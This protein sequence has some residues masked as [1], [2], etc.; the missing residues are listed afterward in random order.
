M[1]RKKR[2]LKK[3]T[4]FGLLIFI[5]IFIILI[6]LFLN[7][8]KTDQY[9]LSKLGYNKTQIKSI[10]SL[11]EKDVETIK[12]VHYDKN[13]PAL[14]ETK[15]FKTDSFKEYYTYQKSHKTTSEE[16]I[17]IINNNLDKL[18]EYDERK[19]ATY[20]NFSKKANIKAHIAVELVNENIE[21]S[22]IILTLKKEKYYK[23]EHL[24][25]YLHYYKK[26]NQDATTIIRDVNANIDYE[27]YTNI[28]EADLTKKD[29]ILV[30]KYY[31]LSEDYVPENLVE[32]EDGYYATKVTSDAYLKMKQD[33]QK[34]GLSLAITSA[35][36]SYNTQDILYNRYTN[37]NGKTWADNYSA[38][39]GHSEHQ[40]GLA[41]DITSNS[42]NFDTFENTKEYQWLKNNSYKYGFIL[43]YQQDTEDI[44]GYH[45]E[46]W[47]YRYVGTEIATKIFNENITYEEYY[48][49]YINK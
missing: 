15:D 49:Y 12:N 48:E 14:I 47:H 17:F 38:R 21:Y 7:Y 3:K 39:P 20:I 11:N 24:K 46:S 10:Q 31:Q 22:D 29:L 33:A 4:I 43:R 23:E 2:K 37:Q 44:T 27:Y 5:V 18:D 8:T 45:Y 42:S 6:V 35:Y 32:I 41:L 30:N 25:R 36:R 34:Q 1:K 16:T 28:K 40:T 19:I 13:I 26:T 9:Q